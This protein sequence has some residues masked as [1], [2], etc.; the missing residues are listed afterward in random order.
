MLRLYY[1]CSQHLLWNIFTAAAKTHAAT[2]L[3]MLVALA[4]DYFHSCC[5]DACSDYASSA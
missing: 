1:L 3:T 4:I 5:Q 2:I